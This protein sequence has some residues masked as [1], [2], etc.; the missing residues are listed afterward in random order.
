M[1]R[2]P[3]AV[4]FILLSLLVTACG[5]TPATATPVPTATAPPPTATAVPPP[6]TNTSPPPPPTATSVPPT[7]LPPTATPVPPTPTEAA[8]DALQIVQWTNYTSKYVDTITVVGLVK[9]MRSYP[10]DQIQ[11]VAEA[12]GADGA[13]V[14]SGNDLL[15]SG[16]ILAPGAT[17]PFRAAILSPTGKADKISLTGQAARFDPN[18]FHIFAPAAGLS[19]EGI[20]LGK[21]YLGAS[22]TG[23][24][25][26]GGSGAATLISVIAAGYDKAGKLVD[27]NNSYAKVDPLAAG[28]T[29]PFQID[30]TREDATI[31][32]VDVWALGTAK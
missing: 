23:R 18:G 25:K 15:L 10:L 6:P 11:I 13:S 12:V 31:T 28:A 14:G 26:N 8:G 3:L 9:N 22:V 1:I 17:L 19:V 4:L 27:V 20:T 32:K 30:M 2:R 21:G 7:P 5:E 24:V 16:A 29:S